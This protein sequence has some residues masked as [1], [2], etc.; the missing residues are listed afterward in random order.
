MSRKSQRT[1]ITYPCMRGFVKKNGWEI[2]DCEHEHRMCG[3]NVHEHGSEKVG[4]LEKAR[5][6]RGKTELS[7]LSVVDKCEVYISPVVNDVVE[8]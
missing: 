5:L 2:C 7:L 4:C 3:D 8:S 6:K 1:N